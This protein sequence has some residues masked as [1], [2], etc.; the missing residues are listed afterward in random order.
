MLVGVIIQSITG[1][2]SAFLLILTT[3]PVA[4]GIAQSS[5]I[6]GR[7]LTGFVSVD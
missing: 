4:P 6:G 7:F 5:F 2:I 3:F 1:D